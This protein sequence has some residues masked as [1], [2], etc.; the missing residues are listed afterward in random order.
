MFKTDN[1]DECVIS[2]LVGWSRDADKGVS[3]DLSV[4]PIDR[5]E[6]LVRS[7][8]HHLFW[9]RDGQKEWQRSVYDR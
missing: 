8:A 5:G 4:K 1:Y 9:R 3:K 7:F 6:E 2:T